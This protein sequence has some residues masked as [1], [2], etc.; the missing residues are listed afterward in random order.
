MIPLKRFSLEKQSG[1][2]GKDYQRNHFLYHFQLHQSKRTSVS[3]KAQLNAMTPIRGREANQ[4][5]SCFI[6]K[7]PYQANVMKTL[8]TINNKMV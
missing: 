3:Y 8:D 6:F 1:K 5:N 2:Y 7:C 4:L